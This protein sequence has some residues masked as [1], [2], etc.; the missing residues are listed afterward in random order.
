MSSAARPL[1]SPP[2]TLLRSEKELR[3]A[4]ASELEILAN[5]RPHF[6]S[7][8]ADAADLASP[9]QLSSAYAESSPENEP[10]SFSYA[11]ASPDLFVHLF[12]VICHH[13]QKVYTSRE[14]YL[15]ITRSSSSHQGK[16]SGVG[17][18]TFHEGS[19]SE[20][21]VCVCGETLTLTL[22]TK[23]QRDESYAGVLRRVLFENCL[24][25]LIEEGFAKN[26]EDLK[27]LLRQYFQLT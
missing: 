13:C 24:N 6:F 23:D 2:S 5:L 1:P 15:N 11:S 16:A 10:I 14:E 22:L 21:R 8:R 4:I 19:L 7:Q 3:Q 20:D 17:A 9:S 18:L 27:G 26:P 12:P 25:K